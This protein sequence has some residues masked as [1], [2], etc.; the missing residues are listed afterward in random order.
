MFRKLILASAV[1]LAVTPSGVVALGLGELR[2]ESALNQPFIAEIDLIDADPNELDTV[3]ATLATDEEF[4]KA[5]AER[6]FYLTKLRFQPDVSPDGRPVLR[7]TSQ[8][9][10]REPFLDFLVEV[11]WPNGRLVREY[12]VLLDP[13]VTREGRPAAP[14][15]PPRVSAQRA[16]R[17]SEATPTR[18]LDGPI[19]GPI[20][21][22]ETADPS[23]FPLYSDPV[24]RGA[25]LLQI[26]RRLAPAGASLPQTVLALYRSNQGAFIAGDI[27]R[28]REGET[29][30]IPSA[31]ELF[32]LGAATAERDLAAALRGQQV[33][34]SP[35]AESPA[36]TV[37]AEA[38]QDRLRIA[39]APTTPAA[40]AEPVA[41]RPPAPGAA[42]SVSNV[43]A[44][45]EEEI[46]L[47]REASETA[48]Q[49]T[50]ELHDRIRQLEVQL[51]DIQNLLALRN[52]QLAELQLAQAIA[53]EDQLTD[54]DTAPSA[55]LSG[56]TAPGEMIALAPED[57]PAELATDEAA[58]TARGE[59]LATP[60]E[61]QPSTQPTVDAADEPQA[62]TRDIG[63]TTNEPAVADDRGVVAG[64][65]DTA[66]GEQPEE[67]PDS[68]TAT[69]PERELADTA[70]EPSPEA[71]QPGVAVTPEVATETPQPTDA[72]PPRPDTAT[73][74]AADI[75]RPGQAAP[76]PAPEGM[77]WSAL[78]IAA[79]LAAL[80]G[81][82]ALYL[83][84]RRRR[85]DASLSIDNSLL[86][87]G[88]SRETDEAQSPAAGDL[89]ASRA[90]NQT[91]LAEDPQVAASGHQTVRPFDDES[92]VDAL[93]EADI[94]I[95]YGRYREAEALLRE[96]INRDPGRLDLQLKLAE[97]LFGMKQLEAFG[98]LLERLKA[99][100]TEASHPEHW[101]RL[102]A[103]QASLEAPSAGEDGVLPGATA[104]AKA[105]PR[106]PGPAQ[107]TEAEPFREAR[108]NRAPI[109]TPA[110]TEPLRVGAPPRGPKA[111]AAPDRADSTLFDMDLDLDTLASSITGKRSP[112]LDQAP[113]RLAFGESERSDLSRFGEAD[114]DL[115]LGELGSTPSRGWQTR[116]DRE[117]ERPHP[118][119]PGPT[120]GPSLDLDLGDSSNDSPD[121]DSLPL[122]LDL[123]GVDI[124]Y[125]RNDQGTHGDGDRLG[126][127][128]SPGAAADPFAVEDSG[129]GLD[130]SS[131]PWPSDSDAWDE[132]ATK[133][134]LARA[135]IDMKDGEAARAILDEIAEEGNEAQRGEARQ[136]LERLG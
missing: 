112:D 65:D 96:E 126:P 74:P 84:R 133:L 87:A 41:T 88:T 22:P 14:V 17:A 79:A 101:Q 92:D 86:G 70:D 99:A 7:V 13:P 103:M 46:L 24:P 67:A 23:A 38:A 115:D 61:E 121:A 26:A 34:S 113:D 8:E 2:T 63:A 119:G 66:L 136:L 102:T 77:P 94:Y 15:R 83:I 58:T 117:T 42:S 89:A 127:S 91:S 37:S 53:A 59:P 60:A 56:D 39:S 57:G 31:A 51:A 43:P 81:A 36:R 3:K 80:L 33:A 40:E 68:S 95:A 93:S 64:G 6:Y 32:A 134:D 78:G 118:K 20:M 128:P 82:G 98:A 50:E 52:E 55:V 18:V 105:E 97:A 108:E 129:D 73:P 49:E 29:L 120:A 125:S 111:A 104:T 71:L 109:A 123:G 10:I 62:L 28:L 5:G 110:G 1:S 47:L 4:D 72:E 69:P 11:N 21:V 85:L 12:T 124:P 122:D 30:I 25:G 130:S 45:L 114:L 131:A 132:V 9:P 16:P 48:R 76:E 27:N 90:A 35:L 107:V 116:S 44:A 106:L 135:Y 19:S 75:T 54:A 100:G